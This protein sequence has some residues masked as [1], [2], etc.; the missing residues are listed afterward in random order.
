VRSDTVGRVFFERCFYL[1]I[2]ILV[3]VAAAPL[4]DPT[5][6]SRLMFNAVNLL[7]AISAV[8]AVGRTVF[9]FVTVLLIAVPTLVFQ[10]LS[11]YSGTS[12]IC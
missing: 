3:L 6:V 8:A 2:V 1:F 11:F 12:S 10:W 9:S 7:V 4:V 5:P